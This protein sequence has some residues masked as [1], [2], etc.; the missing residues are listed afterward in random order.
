MMIMMMIKM[1][2]DTLLDDGRLVT[3]PAVRRAVGIAAIVHGAR[4]RL[5]RKGEREKADKNG[6]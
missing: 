1:K 3:V 5:L 2:Q 6:E 4:A